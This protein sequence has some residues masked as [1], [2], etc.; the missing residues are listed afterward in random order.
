MHVTRLKRA[1]CLGA[2]LLAATP[3]LPQIHDQLA[4]ESDESLKAP[5]APFL[6]EIHFAGPCPGSRFPFALITP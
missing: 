3:V 6:D 2:L 5:E 1:I 4:D